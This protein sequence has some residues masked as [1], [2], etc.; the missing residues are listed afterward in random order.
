MCMFFSLD[1]WDILSF[2][3]IAVKSND[4]LSSNLAI[5]AKP[6]LF[7][8]HDLLSGGLH[9]FFSREVAHDAGFF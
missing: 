9:A 5:L 8:H 2:K 4:R 7:A 6:S 3:W 1:F